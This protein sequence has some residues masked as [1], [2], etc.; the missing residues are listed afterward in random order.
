MVAQ[1]SKII[2]DRNLAWDASSLSL[3]DFNYQLSREALTKLEQSSLPEKYEQIPSKAGDFPAL[4]ADVGY[5]HKHYL[6]KGPGFGI[7]KGLDTARFD[8]AQQEMI[9][10]MV[11]NFLGKP[12]AQNAQGD[13]RYE[14]KDK[15]KTMEQ[16][17]RYSETRQ[18]GVLHTDSI[19]WEQP[20][21]IVGLFC[22]HPAMSG[23]ESV[24]MSAYSVHN[25]LL[26][27]NPELLNILYRPFPFETRKSGG[28]VSTIRKPIF[29]YDERK[30]L[31]FEYIGTYVP[32]DSLTPEQ[33]EAKISLDNLLED[34]NLTVSTGTLAVGEM[35][36]FMNLRTAH[37]R[38]GDF[39]NYPEP[40]RERIM[41]RAWLRENGQ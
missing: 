23:G 40:D 35:F 29:R 30:G 20:P 38:R 3:E 13:I 21:E 27:N 16:G 11:C 8:R 32:V 4:E 34:D 41:I 24:I 2:K 6:K 9:Y 26:E 10:W 5:F 1:L 39:V 33:R 18:A 25:K 28:E 15:G 22:V 36:F 12:L 37:G 14:V 7:I 19:Q 17:G 31:K